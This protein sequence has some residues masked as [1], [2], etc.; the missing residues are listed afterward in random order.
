MCSVFVLSR[1]RRSRCPQREQ[2]CGARQ[3]ASR[4]SAGRRRAPRKGPHAPGPPPPSKPMGPGIL[5]C[6]RPSQGRS[7]SPANSPAPLGAPTLFL[8]GT[9]KEIRRAGPG[10]RIQSQ[11]SRSFGRSADTKTRAAETRAPAFNLSGSDS[12]TL[13][14]HRHRGAPGEHQ[15]R[16]ERDAWAG[17]SAA[18]DRRHVVAAGEQPC[19]RRAFASS[20]R[21]SASAFSPMLLPSVLG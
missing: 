15:R 20:T 7:G 1:S 9:E 10:A 17:I 16:S 14:G 2:G 8:R 18:H 11:G 13:A 19:D 5:A 4:W 6:D 3:L 12:R 21:P